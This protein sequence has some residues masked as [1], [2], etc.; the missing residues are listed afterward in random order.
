MFDL[1]IRKNGVVTEEVHDH[2]LI[3]NGARIAAA[4]FFA[5]DTSGRPIQKI[6]FGTNGTD[7]TDTDTTLV[8]PYMKNVDGFEYPGMGQ[9][10]TNWHLS[11]AEDN[12]QAIME[13]GLIGAD[14]TLLARK[15]R[16]NP[17]HKAS[18]ISLEGRWTIVF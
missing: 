18:D 14:G 11:I 16:V 8:S 1:W 7:P 9:V 10:Q 2:N 4:H 13:F 6:G 3:V 17:I 15:V 5:G 12:G